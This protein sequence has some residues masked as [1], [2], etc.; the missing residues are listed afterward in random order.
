MTVYLIHLSQPFGQPLT[1]E[2]RAAYGRPPR[3]DDKE[4]HARHYIGCT[5]N[6]ARRLEEHQHGYGSRFMAAVAAAGIPWQLA[7]IWPGGWSLEREL[8]RQK[9]SDR[10]CPI[11]HPET[12]YRNKL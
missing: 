7:R 3:K 6:L 12:A 8:K 1:A 2:Q 5:D 11:C 10:L 9:H 4:F